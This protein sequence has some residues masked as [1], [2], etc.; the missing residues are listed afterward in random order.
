MKI[1]I[2]A[3]LVTVICCL[4]VCIGISMAIEKKPIAPVEQT[5]SGVQQVYLMPDLIIEKITIET[6]SSDAKRHNVKIH[7]KVKNKGGPTSRSLTAEGTARSCAGASKALVEWTEN[8][9]KGFNYLC[10]SGI[11]PLAG[12]ASQTFFCTDTVPTG[13]NR[14][15]RATA[16]H[17][18]WIRESNEGN[19]VNSAGY[20]AR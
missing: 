12:G 7:V 14:K 13:H 15:Y 18:D 8:P 6:L 1:G 3:F 16:D 2:K 4:T 5:P 10:E 20:V 17:L 11:S 9:T 19:N